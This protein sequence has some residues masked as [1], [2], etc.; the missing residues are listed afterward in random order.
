MERKFTFL[1]FGIFWTLCLCLAFFNCFWFSDLFF[2]GILLG[3]HSESAKIDTGI[4]QA[5]KD[6][7]KIS[8]TVLTAEKKKGSVLN[9]IR[10]MFG[11]SL[12]FLKGRRVTSRLRRPMCLRW[13]FFMLI[14]TIKTISITRK[15]I[16]VTF[17]FWGKLP[18]VWTP[19]KTRRITNL[20]QMRVRFSGLSMIL[21]P[22]SFLAWWKH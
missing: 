1:L 18:P 5:V 22:T 16:I 13:Q 6:S 19:L 7:T 4:S 21:S 8:M 10:Q 3:K 11:K 12:D 17:T 20:N 15:F 14:N 9:A 2:S